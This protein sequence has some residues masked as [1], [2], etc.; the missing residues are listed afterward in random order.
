MPK[1]TVFM[2]VYNRARTIRESVDSVLAQTF[3][4]FELLLIDD[5]STDESVRIIESYDDPRIRLVRHEENQ[6][7]PKTR[8][9][10]LRLAEGEYLAL[11]D[12]DDCACPK[13]LERQVRMLDERPKI[14]AVGS[15][16]KQIDANSHTKGILIRPVLPRQIHAR[17][18]F[19][20]CFKNP[21]MTARTDLMRKF[22]Y[23]EQFVF[24][25]DIDMWARMSVEHELANIPE[26]LTRY[27]SGGASHADPE[28]SRKLI[29]IVA[30]DQMELLG[31]DFTNEDIDRH[32]RLRHPSGMRP[33][34]D[35]VRW[36]CEW[37]ERLV[38]TN[39]ARK[40]YPQPEFA[41]AAAE[42]WL[43][44]SIRA[45]RAGLPA[46]RL[47][48]ASPIRR[49]LPG[50]LREYANVGFRFAPGAALSFFP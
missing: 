26:F 20:T 40:L 21:A 46:L 30:R 34:R 27:R 15:W 35:Y 25:Q 29:C 31:I 42:R 28:L 5:G 11:L 13:R 24:C 7:I 39:R 12:S 38:E 6:G 22:G 10:G 8:N 14:A 50:M 32:Y 48:L 49:A 18:P 41:R 19:V 1:V 37:L 4:D 44:V 43:H 47:A 45:A 3:T 2:P 36:C 33:D 17:I 16:L 23:R 9:D